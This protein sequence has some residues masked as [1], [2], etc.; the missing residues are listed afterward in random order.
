VTIEAPA[1]SAF[2]R[3]RRGKSTVEFIRRHF[4]AESRQFICQT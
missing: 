2:R 1:P 3:R 4:E